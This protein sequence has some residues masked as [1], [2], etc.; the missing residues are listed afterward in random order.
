LS[1]LVPAAVEVVRRCGSR[2]TQSPRF[3]F[4]DEFQDTDATQLEL[5]L[6]LKE[7][8]DAR[9]FVVG[10]VKQGVYR[11]RGAQGN[12]FDEL[13]EQCRTRGLPPPSRYSLVRNFRSGP[14][15]LDSLHPHFAAWGREGWL[16][17][18]GPDRLRPR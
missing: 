10:D 18:D 6:S 9:L 3:V 2:L 14:V 13:L 17:Y 16:T 8:L 7:Q 5:V 1:Q 12:A 15:L 11:F 4:V